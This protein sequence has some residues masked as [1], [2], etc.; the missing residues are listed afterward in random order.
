MTYAS[1]LARDPFATYRQIDAVG[2]TATADGPALV[3]LLYKE[4]VAALRAAAW[5]CEK[6]KFAVKSERITRA[7][8]ILFALEAG[9]DFEKGGQVSETLARL[10]GGARKTVINA[11]L[12]HDPKP[13]RDSADML[14]EIAQAWRTASAA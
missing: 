14:D 9:L 13:F 6:R 8:A 10:Y 1:T 4:L 5:A 11:S 7:T 2:R 12:G 3:Q